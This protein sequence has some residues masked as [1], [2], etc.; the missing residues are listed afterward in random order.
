[1]ITSVVLNAIMQ[2][3]YCICILFCLGDYDTVAASK[4]PLVEVYY[5]A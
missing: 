4:L 3:G 5:G 2:V 1:M